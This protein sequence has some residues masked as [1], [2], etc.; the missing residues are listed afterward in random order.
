MGPRQ[1]PSSMWGTEAST[2]TAAITAALLLSV[3]L[4]IGCSSKPIATVKIIVESSTFRSWE[5]PYNI[6]DDIS[7]K[8]AKGGFQIVT[9]ENEPYDAIMFLY[10]KETKSGLYKMQ[11]T[12]F[13]SPGTQITCKIHVRSTTGKTLLEHTI[14]GITKGKTVLHGPEPYYKL[15]V[16]DFKKSVY[17]EYVDEILAAKFGIGD[18]V[19]VL[20]SAM[21]KNIRKS[22]KVKT[23]KEAAESLGEIGDI[24]AV[25]PLIEA[26]R[27]GYIR[28]KIA[29]IKA[30]TK[31]GDANAVDPLI[32]KLRYFDENV[33][34]EAAI[35]L[36]V[37]RDPRAI[38]ALREVAEKDYSKK[39]QRAAKMVLSGIEEKEKGQ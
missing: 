37:F 38:P 29:A 21:E 9:K 20:I 13:N 17:F 34:I 18:E 5:A 25:E 4:T 22:E 36:G 12:N 33:R 31:I 14:K 1:C 16:S 6:R 27:H 10:Y 26:L 7:K 32:E 3:L 35:A 8:L 19:T 11:G 39:V 28:T 30:L 24:R 23:A 15:A 2:L